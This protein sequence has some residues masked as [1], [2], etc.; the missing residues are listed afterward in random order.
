VTDTGGTADFLRHQEGDTLI[1]SLVS[2]SAAV[3]QVRSVEVVHTG[4]A[5]VD[6]DVLSSLVDAAP[7]LEVR[8]NEVQQADQDPEEVDHSVID[9]LIG[10]TPSRDDSERS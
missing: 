7:E 6:E 2:D 5:A 3:E 8:S 9:D 1:D 10:D 4:E